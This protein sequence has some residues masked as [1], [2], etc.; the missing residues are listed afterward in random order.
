MRVV[1]IRTQSSTML[2]ESLIKGTTNNDNRQ[3]S[4]RF[5]YVAERTE[6]R[7]RYRRSLLGTRRSLDG[8]ASDAWSL[9]AGA[10]RGIGDAPGA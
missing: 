6:D 4:E 1:V 10:G 5:V 2:S 3:S 8:C 7:I 9:V